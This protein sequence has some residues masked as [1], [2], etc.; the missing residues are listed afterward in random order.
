MSEKVR[1]H[2]FDNRSIDES[3]LYEYATVF[4]DTRFNIGINLAAQLHG[5]A[6]SGN[7][8]F[9][10]FSVDGRLNKLKLETIANQLSFPGATHTDD[11]FYIFG[12]V[13]GIVVVIHVMILN[14][15]LF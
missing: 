12:Y 11:L 9:Y 7:T 8:F 15:V 2:Y 4:S 5:S 3:T 10:K 1:R 13:Y 6:S 14:C